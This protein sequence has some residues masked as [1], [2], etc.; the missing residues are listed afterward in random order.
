M[1]ELIIGIVI[2]YVFKD[3]IKIGIRIVKEGIKKEMKQNE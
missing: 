3:F 1:L 2:G